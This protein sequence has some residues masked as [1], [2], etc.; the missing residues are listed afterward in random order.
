MA[1]LA[2]NPGIDMKTMT[3]VNIVRKSV[4]TFPRNGI[5]FI[6][7]L[8]EF[9]DLRLGFLCYGVTIHAS[10]CGWNNRVSRPIDSDVAVSTINFHFARMKLVGKSDWLLWCVTDAFPCGPGNKISDSNGG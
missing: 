7:I 6:I 8:R 3:E 4:N 10:A 1:V 2:L 9:N 5:P